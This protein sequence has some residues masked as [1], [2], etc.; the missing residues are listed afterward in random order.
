MGKGVND[1]AEEPYPI[2]TAVGGAWLVGFDFEIKVI[3]NYP[4]DIMECS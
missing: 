2:W 1:H 3:A 4:S